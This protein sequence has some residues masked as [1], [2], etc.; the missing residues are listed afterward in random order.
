MDT[1][2]H[3]PEITDGDLERLLEA[4][5]RDRQILVP[6]QSADEPREELDRQ[7]LAGLVSPV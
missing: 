4:S 5:D 1:M 7:I 3:T 6:A 2:P